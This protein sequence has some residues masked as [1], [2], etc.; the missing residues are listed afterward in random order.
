[1]FTQ[2]GKTG[3]DEG[4]TKEDKHHPPKKILTT[5]PALIV[6]KIVTIRETVNDTN[7]KIS[8]RI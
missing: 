3:N 6:E 2:R 5:S 1:M 4:E 7:R 8:K